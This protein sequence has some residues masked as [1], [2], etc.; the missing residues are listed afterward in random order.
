M[1]G[2]IFWLVIGAFVGA[3]LVLNDSD[4]AAWFSDVFEML[5]TYLGAL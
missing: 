4:T 3:Y 2:G 1:R 5:Q